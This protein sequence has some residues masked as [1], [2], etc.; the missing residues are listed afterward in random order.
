MKLRVLFVNRMLKLAIDI[1]N[2]IEHDLDVEMKHINYNFRNGTKLTLAYCRLIFVVYNL[3]AKSPLNRCDSFFVY[4]PFNITNNY[5]TCLFHLVP[6]KLIRFFF[7][8]P[9][10]N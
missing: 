10:K 7:V 2:K 3:N 4:S 8:Q 9:K 5:E 1:Q 6:I